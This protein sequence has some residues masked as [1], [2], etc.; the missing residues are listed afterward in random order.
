MDETPLEQDGD[1][2]VAMYWTEVPTLEPLEGAETETPANAAE[3][4]TREQ[5]IT[6]ET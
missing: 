4:V 2:E 6:R 5:M 1:S 3:A